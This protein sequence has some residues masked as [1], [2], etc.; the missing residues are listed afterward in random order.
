MGYKIG[1]GTRCANPKVQNKMTEGVRMTVIITDINE[2][3]ISL[4]EKNL[5]MNQTSH[6]NLFQ[7]T[8]L[9]KMTHNAS[10]TKW[11]L[12]TL[13]SGSSVFDRPRK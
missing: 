13:T 11:Y 8:D 12:G 10:E 7:E 3:D 2:L 1:N 6:F 9:K 4:E 5:R